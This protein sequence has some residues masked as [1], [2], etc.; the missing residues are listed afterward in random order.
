VPTTKPK[1][2]G[3]LVKARARAHRW[4]R[5]LDAGVQTSVTEIAVAEGPGP[6]PSTMLGRASLQ[7]RRTAPLRARRSPDVNRRHHLLRLWWS[8]WQMPGTTRKSLPGSSLQRRRLLPNIEVPVVGARH[9][10]HWRRQLSIALPQG[11][12]GREHLRALCRA[13]RKL[14]RARARAVGKARS[15]PARLA[16]RRR[17][18]SIPRIVL[19]WARV[20]IAS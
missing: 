20:S 16:A 9:D 18:H 1:P 14:R 15:P 10:H 2:D 6:R 8:M 19:A 7:A 11:R 5:L 13:R 12:Y 17:G 3:A 4:K